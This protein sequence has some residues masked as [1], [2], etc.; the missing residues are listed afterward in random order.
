[1]SRHH[2]ASTAP[3][4]FSVPAGAGSPGQMGGHKFPPPKTTV[5]FFTQPDQSSNPPV[6]AEEVGN[7]YTDNPH[8]FQVGQEV[9]LDEGQLWTVAQIVHDITTSGWIDRQ[10][11]V[12]NCYLNPID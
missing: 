4:D 12:L 8:L 3:A 11:H 7:L 2:G 1:M 10:E 6:E 9:R 5:Y